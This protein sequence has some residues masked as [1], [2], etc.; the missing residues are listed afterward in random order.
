MNFLLNK[1]NY[2]PKAPP[3]SLRLGEMAGRYSP[4]FSSAPDGRPGT[5]DSFP[6]PEPETDEMK[7]R[8][9]IGNKGMGVKEAHEAG[10]GD[11]VPL[12]LK[13]GPCS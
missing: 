13:I 5:K 4:E 6:R 10:G 1:K 12:V 3:S 2:P 8:F 9:S 11:V 7:L